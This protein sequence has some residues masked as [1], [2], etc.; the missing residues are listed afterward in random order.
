M[1]KT[2]YIN[3][4]RYEE[5]RK[6]PVFFL[7]FNENIRYDNKGKEIDFSTWDSHDSYLN[8]SIKADNFADRALGYC[9]CI[10][11]NAEDKKDNEGNVIPDEVKMTFHNAAPNNVNDWIY[12]I[13]S[14][15]IRS[16]NKEDKY[17]F[18]ELLWALDKLTWNSPTL[19]SAFSRYPSQTIPFLI[20]NFQ[21][22]GRVLS[23]YK[24]EELKLVCS[25]F[26]G[27]YSIYSPEILKQAYDCLPYGICPTIFQ[28][29]PDYKSLN[30][31][32]IID[33]IFEQYSLANLDESV[34]KT[35]TIIMLHSWLHSDK[36]LGDYNVL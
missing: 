12:I 6:N 29:K 30:L 28:R 21:K 33:A 23:Y 17:A 1:E 24:Q 5:L 3:K 25:T 27:Q 2:A 14:F 19:I 8:I 13:N 10:I 7:R 11:D 16:Q 36:P 34:V 31:F 35:N 15:V 4:S 9:L 32:S 18:L 20:T 22:F 26:N